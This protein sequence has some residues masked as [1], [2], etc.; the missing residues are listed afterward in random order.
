MGVDILLTGSVIFTGERVLRRGYVYVKDGK[1]EGVGEGVVPE[2]Y[3][4]ATL[5]LGGEGRIIAPG[6]AALASIATYPIRLRKP[7]MA[8]R[9]RFYKSSGLKTLM[10]ASLPAVYELHMS[11]VTVVIVEGLDVSLPLELSKTVG[12]FYGLAVPVCSG[13]QPDYV[14]GLVAVAT[15]SG[16]GCEGEGEIR[17]VEG[18]GMTKLGS[19]LSFF[20]S[21][22]FSLGSSPDPWEENVALRKALSL[23]PPV[24]KPGRIAEI[25]VFDASRPPAM[26]LDLADDRDIVKVYSSGA[27]LESLIAG[28][29]ILVDTGEHLYI[30]EKQFRETRNL[31]ERLKK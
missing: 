9:V 6:L 14:P 28:E 17:E 1:I 4:Y 26:L 30:T 15:L 23:P 29:D 24:I 21:I 13:V 19:V 16:E 7:S 8:E 25:A 10:T 5:V 27:R 31:A 12:G 11:G 18:K 22:S 2:E 3:T 20:N